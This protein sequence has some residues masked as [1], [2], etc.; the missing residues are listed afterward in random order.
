MNYLRWLIV[1]PLSMFILH[2]Y[3]VINVTD[4]INRGLYLKL[5]G[6]I[7]KNDFI[8]FCLNKEYTKVGLD[9][10][11]LYAGLTCHGAIP[12]MKKVI[13]T[14]H[15]NVK[16]EDNFLIVNGKPFSYST[17]KLDHQGHTIHSISRGEYPNI[18]G[19]FVVG[20]HPDSWDSRYWGFITPDL[21]ISRLIPLVTV[22]NQQHWHLG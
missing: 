10:H 5:K 9:S 14:P 13:A 12:L 7:S 4:S 1:L 20:E 18:K 17:K 15:D 19:Y 3:F 21:I 11:Y 8:L 22:D 16:L 2:H 6:K